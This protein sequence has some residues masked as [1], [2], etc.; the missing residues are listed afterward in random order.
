MAAKLLFQSNIEFT[1][2]NYLCFHTELIKKASR[3]KIKAKFGYETHF[4]SF[5]VLLFRIILCNAIYIFC[6][7]FVLFKS[8]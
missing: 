5:H 6:L 1:A 8:I 4:T 7:H 2:K 3:D